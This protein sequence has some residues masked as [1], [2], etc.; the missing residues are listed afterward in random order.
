MSNTMIIQGDK[1]RVRL[2]V[3][4][5]ENMLAKSIDDAN[6]L[7]AKL[8]VMAGPFSGSITLALT[9][10]ELELLHRKL[11]NA[12]KLLTGNIEFATMEGNLRLQM[13]FER[14]GEVLV[15]GSVTQDEAEENVL[16]YYF[17]TD[18][19]TL[20]AVVRDLERL[21]RQFPVKHFVSSTTG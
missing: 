9:S 21:V 10:N 12:I 8:D 13:T 20:E 17:L 11:S 18:P 3:I 2:E 6:W 14:T 5:Y 15:Q 7:Q 1:G 4:K 19:I 16:Q